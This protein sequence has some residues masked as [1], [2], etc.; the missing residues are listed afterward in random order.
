MLFVVVLKLAVYGNLG[1][2]SRI[3]FRPKLVLSGLG[4]FLKSFRAGAASF[5]SDSGNQGRHHKQ[6]YTIVCMKEISV[7]M[8]KC[9][10]CCFRA[11]SLSKKA[12]TLACCCPHV[13]PIACKSFSTHSSAHRVAIQK[14]SIPAIDQL[15]LPKFP[16][17]YFP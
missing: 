9:L 16:D 7:K 12:C 13:S 15:H 5:R 2:T 8:S 6:T 4:S 17:I 3:L 14:N 10:P 11:P 1:D